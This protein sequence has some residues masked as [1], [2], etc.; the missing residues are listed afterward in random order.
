MS[1]R[2]LAAPSGSAVGSPRAVSDAQPYMAP[3]T[4]PGTSLERLRWSAYAIVAGAYVLSFFHRVA[5]A[6]I[7][8]DLAQAFH[9]SGVALGVLSATYFY[10]YTVMQIPTGVLVDRFGTRRI[11]TLGGMLAGA[12]SVVFGAAPTFAVATLGRTLVGLGVSVMFVALLKLVAEW[13]HEREFATMAGVTVFLGNMGAILSAA[14]LAWLV[15][16]VSWRSVFLAAGLVSV[17]LGALCWFFVHDRPQEVGLASPHEFPLATHRSTTPWQTGLIE[18][19]RNPYS[20]PGFFANIGLAGTLLTFVGLWG[21]PYLVQAHGMTRTT[22]TW[23]T[24]AMLMGFALGA[25]TVGFVSD[26]LRRRKPVLLALA[27]VYCASWLPWL[28]GTSMPT[29]ASVLLCLAMGVAGSAFTLTLANAKEVNRRAH[30]GMAVSLVNTGVFLGAAI[31]QPLVGW[32]LDRAT[33]GAGAHAAG[34][35][36]FRLAIGALAAAALVGLAG[37]TFLRET[38]CHNIHRE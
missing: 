9:T 38:N 24:S 31:L 32:I 10:V 30:A 17:I 11:V 8:G 15:T 19:M 26:R 7:A 6:A 12:G 4:L 21:V 33:G 27:A 36:A 34:P 5:P 23:H 28:L 13:F 14:P 16:V 29:A 22:A 1:F 18:V 2:A 25:M 37:A 20:W 3:T 35:E